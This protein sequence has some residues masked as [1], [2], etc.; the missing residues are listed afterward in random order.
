MHLTKTGKR[1]RAL[2]NAMTEPEVILWSRL[3]RLRAEGFHIRR[4]SPFRGYILDFVCFDRR[5]VIEVDGAGHGEGRQIVHDE[6]RDAVLQR[7]G[8]QVLRFWN[9]EVRTN[10]DGVMLSIREALG[11]PLFPPRSRRRRESP[12]P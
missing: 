1:A 8:F 3:K 6:V 9:A 7:E 12:S 10:L 2:R 5:V 4:Q 11:P